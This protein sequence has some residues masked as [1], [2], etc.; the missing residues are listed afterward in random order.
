MLPMDTKRS[1][2]TWR[3][4]RARGYAVS[5]VGFQLEQVRKYIREQE[6]ADGNSGSF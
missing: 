4:E 5:T 1:M 6:S 3:R 2:L